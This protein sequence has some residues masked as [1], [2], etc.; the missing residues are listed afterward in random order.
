MDFDYAY[1][2]HPAVPSPLSLRSIY[3]VYADPSYDVLKGSSQP[4]SHVAFRTLSGSGGI[5]LEGGEEISVEADSL[6]VCRQAD[7]RRYRCI[8]VNWDF[9]WFEF[10]C[11][12]GPELPLGSALTVR[13]NVQE[14]SDCRRAL[15]LL[16]EGTRES[17]V[18]ASALTAYLLHDWRCRLAEPAIPQA[19]HRKSVEELIARL[20]REDAPSPTVAEMA[21]QVG[22]GER[23]FRQVFEAV[24]GCAPKRYLVS[25]RM[26]RAEEL[27]RNT[28]FSIGTISDRLGYQNA[29]HFSREFSKHAGMP[30]SRFRRGKGKG[31]G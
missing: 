15:T 5:R 25:L 7:V 19:P 2:E 26:Q 13:W 14:A 9:W 23:R 10:H 12:C 20:R 22:L 4:A 24:V 3:L 1:T 21:R 29:F 28:P 30:P 11:E 8:G 27:L 6:I 16:K 31:N 17:L 18:A